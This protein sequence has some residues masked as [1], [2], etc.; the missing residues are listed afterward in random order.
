MSLR[1]FCLFLEPVRFVLY[2]SRNGVDFDNLCCV[3]LRDSSLRSWRLRL[4]IVGSSSVSSR[5]CFLYEYMQYAV[6]RFPRRLYDVS[7][8]RVELDKKR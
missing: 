1:A 2:R 5:D 7:Y 6:C 3:N 4:H 8:H